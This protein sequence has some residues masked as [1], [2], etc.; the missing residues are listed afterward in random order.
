MTPWIAN[1]YDRLIGL[2]LK[3]AFLSDVTLSGC[4]TVQTGVGRQLGEHFAFPGLL[5]RGQLRQV[6]IEAMSFGFHLAGQPGEFGRLFGGRHIHS[7][8]E[9]ADDR[10]AN[11]GKECPGASRN[12]AS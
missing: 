8:F 6:S 9:V 1:C 11:V 3:D 5:G 7:V 2:E 12:H 4:S 10:L